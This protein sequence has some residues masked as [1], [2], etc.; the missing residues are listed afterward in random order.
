MGRG[1][2][3]QSKQSNWVR[4]PDHRTSTTPY[5]VKYYVSALSLKEDRKCLMKLR[6]IN[7]VYQSSSN[8]HSFALFNMKFSP[9][10]TALLPFLLSIS[11]NASTDVYRKYRDLA[12][13][14]NP[15]ILDESSYDELTTG[16]RNHS[17]AVLLTARDARYGCQMCRQFQP[18]WE[19]IAKSWLKG[20]KVGDSK[21]VFGTL[22]FDN[23]KPVFQ[24]VWRDSIFIISTANQVCSSCFKPLRCYSSLLP[25]RDLMQRLIL[26]LSASTF[27]LGRTCFRS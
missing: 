11:V 15:V 5:K 21:L 16:P 6:S 13:T 10:F 4:L 8:P 19:L 2:V 17:V 3:V 14:T 24:K 22:D 27:L 9:T 20:D 23:G 26:H 1:A 25:P 12:Q 7:S 18:E